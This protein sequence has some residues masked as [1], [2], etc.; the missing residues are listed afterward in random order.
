MPEDIQD[1]LSNWFAQHGNH[2]FY[3]SAEDWVNSMSNWD[4]LQWIDIFNKDAREADQLKA[5]L[6]RLNNNVA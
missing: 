5:E 6:D 1:Y 3:S 2:Q 4:L